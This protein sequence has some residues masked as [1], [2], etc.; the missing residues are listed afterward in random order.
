MNERVGG[1][2][3]IDIIDERFEGEFTGEGE[4]HGYGYR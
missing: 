1:A 3:H 2:R 4:Y